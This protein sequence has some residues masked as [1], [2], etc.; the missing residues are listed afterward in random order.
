MWGC[1]S[2]H[3]RAMRQTCPGMCPASV[4]PGRTSALLVLRQGSPPSLVQDEE[5]S[6]EDQ[7]SKWGGLLG[8]PGLHK[9]LR[10][11]EFYL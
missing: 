7:G 6:P 2:V 8:G 5:A 3:T 9:G 11:V 1:V 4:A 10:M